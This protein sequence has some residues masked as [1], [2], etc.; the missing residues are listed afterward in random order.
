MKEQHPFIFW[1]SDPV[2]PDETLVLAGEDFAENA[3]VELAEA[4]GKWVAVKPVQKSRQCLKTVIPSEF[5]YGT[6]QCRV[7][8]GGEVSKE[9]SVNAPDVWWKQGD[10]GVDA[11]FPGSWLRLFGKCL[12]LTGNS[13][14]RIGKKEFPCQEQDCF[15]LKATVPENMQTGTFPLEVFNGSSWAAAG[16]LE[17]RERKRD[18]RIVLDLLS[19]P[20]ADPTGL[21]DSTLAFVQLLERARCIPGGA[22]IEI[23]RGRFRIDANL[24]P[25]TY[26]DSQLFVMENVTLR[27]AGPNLTTLWWPDKKEALPV[28]IECANN[29][30]LENLAIYAQGPLHEVVKTESHVRIENVMIRAN[31]YYMLTPLGGG[32]HHERSLPPRDQRG[33]PGIA[34]WGTNNR[35][36]NCDILSAQGINVYNGAGSVISGNRICGFGQH[37][38]CGSEI[39]YENNT[40]TGGMITGGCNIAMFGPTINR[41]VYYKGNSSRHLYAGDHECLTLDGHGT[42]YFGKVRNIGETTFDLIGGKIPFR[43]KGSMTDMKRTAVYIVDGRGTGQIR[44]LSSYSEKGTVTID[45]PWEVPPDGSSILEIGV[46]NGDHLILDNMAEDGGALVQL[47]PKNCRCIVARNRGL[48]TGNIN[49]LSRSGTWPAGG[50]FSRLTRFE[51]SWYNQFFENEI[52]AG[53]AWGGGVTEVDRWL[54]GESKLLI[55]GECKSRIVDESGTLFRREQTPE[56]LRAALGEKK[57]RDRNVSPSRYQIVRRHVIRSNSSIHIRGVVTDA[58]IEHCTIADS[59]RGIRVDMEVDRPFPNNCG[60]TY[61][62]NPDPDE[63][64]P[65]MPFQR[66]EGIL[67]RGNVFSNVNQPYAGTALEY[68]VIL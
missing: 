26:M 34:I 27:G 5:R 18:E 28:L 54:G 6:W 35:I 62:W 9:I 58:L 10:G 53:N 33:G 63:Q 4:K 47:Y 13:K 45:H 17:I 7:R 56:W 39:I 42:A 55:H 57:L 8:Q 59:D 24:R 46:Y 11:A 64:H 60:Q 32:T 43:G 15:A 61:N 25:M 38:I 16:T 21:K 29:S 44:F 67:I 48:R 2:R 41:H 49:S 52:L 19:H 36:L 3:L 66:P 50:D 12:N 22:I 65:P 37:S 51:I 31:S 30:S 23:P 68:A 14:L 1:H 40:F 20:N